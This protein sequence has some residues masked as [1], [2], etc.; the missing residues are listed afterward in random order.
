MTFIGKGE[1][2]Q[3]HLPVSGLEYSRHRISESWASTFSISFRDC[4]SYILGYNMVHFSMF[5]KTSKAWL[6]SH[7]WAVCS[8]HKKLYGIT[9]ECLSCPQRP[10]A[11]RW[12]SHRQFVSP[13]SYLSLVHQLCLHFLLSCNQ[14]PEVPE[15]C[16]LHRWFSSSPGDT[17]HP[18]IFTNYKI[19]KQ[20]ICLSNWAPS[21]HKYFIGNNAVIG[22]TF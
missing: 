1:A 15:C 20:N 16:H 6:F 5:N 10:S 21:Q 13:P 9:W 19:L 4:N 7:A 11:P 17:I 8:L 2:A 12:D 14:C 3:F 18:E 22:R